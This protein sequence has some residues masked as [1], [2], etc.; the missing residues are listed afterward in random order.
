MWLTMFLA[1]LVARGSDITSMKIKDGFRVELVHAVDS[2]TEGSWIALTVDDRG[3]LIASSQYGQLFRVEPGGKVEALKL[4][5]GHAHGLLYAFNSLYVVVAEDK[6]QGPGLYRAR[7]TNG[8]DHFDQVEQLR[9]LSGTGEH[10]PHSIVLSPDGASLFVC[11]GNKTS[12]PELATSRVPTHWG[13]D[14]LLPRIWGPIGSEVGTPAPGGWIARTDLDGE[15]WELFAVG[16]RNAFDMAFNRQGDL[17][18][19]DADAEFD[20]GTPWYQPTRVLHVASGIDYG[21]R[22]GAGK[23][24][25]HFADTL[26]P[27][28]EVG[29]GSPTGVAFAYE[30]K[31]PSRYRNAMFLCDWSY[32]RVFALHLEPDG[33]SYRGELE[34]FLTGTPLPISDLVVNPSDGALYFTLGGRQTTSGLYR[35]EYVGSESTSEG[36]HERH[37]T[38][39]QT[40]ENLHQSSSP[41]EAID[42]AWN[43]LGSGDRFVRHAARMTLELAP[44]KSWRERAIIERDPTSR[45]TAILALARAGDPSLLIRLLDSLDQLDWDALDFEQRLALLR[46]YELTLIRMGPPNPTA[47]HNSLA[48]RMTAWL[49][50]AFP[51]NDRL[52]DPELCKLLVYLQSD[53]VASK[54]LSLLKSGSTRQEELQYTLLLRHLQA[55]WTPQLRREYF[56]RLDLAS[57]RHGGRSFSKYIETIRSD[58]FANLPKELRKDFAQTAH[59]N[60]Q[61]ISKI[62]SQRRPFVRKWTLEDLSPLTRKQL[63]VR[64]TLNGRRTFGTANCFECHR[65]AG[66]GRTVGSDLTT[67][68]RRFNVHDLLESMISP[69]KVISDQYAA[70]TIIKQNGQIVTGRVVNLSG[71]TLM[72]Q[73]DMLQP[74]NLLRIPKSEI[75]E[76]APSRTSLMPEGLLDTLTKDEILDLIAFMFAEIPTRIGSD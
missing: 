17:F 2:E 23:W 29:A 61:S 12:L 34:E 39:R 52:L 11:A 58:A 75:E 26:P 49:E 15:S 48:A 5:V 27:V 19:F 18:T 22:S 24:P 44:P 50:K 7:D 25:P 70:T 32:G 51:S 57:N 6:Y 47:L 38:P 55:G 62:A 30:A 40:L 4:S 8:D 14:D 54:T 20:M 60:S 16:L 36:I 72:I 69:N 37:E 35:V 63:G 42:S 13:E 71:E 1:P 74:A 31:F 64:D 9:E 68:A 41:Q 33:A 3:R 21:W 65:I 53:L 59:G 45:L 46:C 10:G 73:T 28:V 66:E 56:D 76:M 43:H 67:V